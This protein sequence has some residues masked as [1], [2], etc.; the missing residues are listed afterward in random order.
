MEENKELSL[1]PEEAQSG[2]GTSHNTA[3]PDDSVSYATISFAKLCQ[4]KAGVP[5]NGAD[6]TVTYSTD[7]CNSTTWAFSGL[8]DTAAVELATHGQIHKDVRAKSARL[9]VTADCSLVI[10]KVTVEDAGRYTC[11]QI[12]SGNEVSEFDVYLSVINMTQHD[13]SKELILNC[14]VLAY[15]P[16]AYTVEWLYEGEE[17]IYTD[18]KILPGSCSSAVTFKSHLNQ[19][20]KF[21]ESLKCNVTDESRNKVKLFPF[22]SQLSDE[23][24]MTTKKSTAAKKLMVTPNPAPEEESSKNN[25]VSLVCMSTEEAPFRWIL[26]SLL[27]LQCRGNS[28]TAAQPR[29]SNSTSTTTIKPTPTNETEMISSGDSTTTT[30][31]NSTNTT[32]ISPSSQTT[33]INGKEKTGSK[34]QVEETTKVAGEHSCQKN[35]DDEDV[36]YVS[37][38]FIR[39]SKC[40]AKVCN[41]NDDEDDTVTYSTVK[42]PSSSDGVSTD[43]SDLYSAINKQKKQVP[44]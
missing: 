44:A 25:A 20:S 28:T 6:D 10:N 19:K 32:T 31:S 18:M 17:N 29:T 24:A 34:T 33:S 5:C 41:D 1:N 13:N 36:S 30:T 27:I 2:S 12:K 8:T 14:S 23:N 35:A 22:S 16:C 11:R 21:Y 37:V 39:R 42:F 40:K 38:S 4:N 15:K 3:E 43:P 26:F 9:S 7:D